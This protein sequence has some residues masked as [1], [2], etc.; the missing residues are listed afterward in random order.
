M[1]KVSFIIPVLNAQKVLNSCLS[2]INKQNYSKSNYEIIIIDGGST[3][4]T[5][6]IAKTYNSKIYKNPLKTAEAG[7]A[8]G[9]KQAKGQYICLIDSDNI[10]PSTNWLKKML[11][12]LEENNQ[13]IGSEPIKFTYRK[14]SGFIERYSALIGAN[15]PYAFITGVYDRQNLINNK[16]T[17]L[18]IDQ[19]DKKQYLEVILKPNTS[20]PTIGANGTIFRSNFLKK[21]L[22]SDY[23]FDI[24]I[25]SQVINQTKKPLLFAKVK[26]GIIH[27]FCENSLPKFIRKQ[28]RRITDYFYYQNLRQFNWDQTNKSGVF[29]YALY[30]LLIIPTLITSILGFIKK[31]DF[32]WFFHPFACLITLWMYTFTTIKYRL[33]LLKPLNRKTWH[34]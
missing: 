21:N 32:A 22:K 6:S 28:N 5:L 15:D 25:I 34:A 30:T 31:P 18:K 20:I 12:P 2:S 23:L 26:I 10:L 19:I 17:G 9:I 24:D 1:I 11:F 13:I 4:K 33:G 29:K 27:T 7:K 3:D 14:N 16:W 8:V